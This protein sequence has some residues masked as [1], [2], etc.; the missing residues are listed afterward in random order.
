MTFRTVARRGYDKYLNTEPETVAYLNSLGAVAIYDGTL[1]G[2]N[3]ANL[4]SAGS[5]IDGVPTA[6][7]INSTGMLFNGTTSQ[8][9]IPNHVSWVDLPAYTF[10]EVMQAAT[11]G[12]GSS[13]RGWTV[14]S[15]SHTSNLTATPSIVAN[16]ARATTAASST[17]SNPIPAYPSGFFIIF[18]GWDGTNIT[19]HS[20]RVGQT[21]LVAGTNSN[22]SGAVTTHGAN[23]LF[24]GNRNGADRTLD[25]YIKLFAIV[26]SVLDLS[27]RTKVAKV[28]GIIP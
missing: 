8:I 19:G 3:I 13:G 20:A 24:L 11:I 15:T 14:G 28:A 12:E 23:N 26:P 22:G 5:A 1:N 21:A 10:I 25:G 2:S 6:V 4:G 18:M 27:T 17:M 16:V 7:T 9:V